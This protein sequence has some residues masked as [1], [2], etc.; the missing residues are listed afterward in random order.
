MTKSQFI[1]EICCELIKEKIRKDAPLSE[2][3]TKIIARYA[4]SIA[5]WSEQHI[6]FEQENK[7]Q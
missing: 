3:R 2:E 6:T 7:Q 5:E 4:E 1:S